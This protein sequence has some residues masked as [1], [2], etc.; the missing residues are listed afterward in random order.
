MRKN[1]KNEQVTLDPTEFYNMMGK[2]IHSEVHDGKK[3]VEDWGTANYNMEFVLLVLLC[4]VLEKLGYNPLEECETLLQ[5]EIYLHG[6]ITSEIDG[7][8]LEKGKVFD[9]DDHEVPGYEIFYH[10]QKL[11]K[12]FKQVQ[13]EWYASK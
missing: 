6:S 3:L 2:L 11:G 1:T 13:N 5:Y 7:L 8:R 9:K 12:S 10:A 4:T